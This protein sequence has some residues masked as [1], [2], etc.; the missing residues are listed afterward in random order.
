MWV[1]TVAVEVKE[2]MVWKAFTVSFEVEDALRLIHV[3]GKHV[4]W[5]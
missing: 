4:S 2:E 1:P 5:S 3:F